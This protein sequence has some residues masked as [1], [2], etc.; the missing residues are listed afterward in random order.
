MDKKQISYE[1]LKVLLKSNQKPILIDVRSKE[2]VAK[3]QI[4]GSIHVPVDTVK[5]AFE[6]DP[7]E[8]KA[9]YGITK[10]LKDAPNLVFHCHMG[11]RGG[12]ATDM[13]HELG[14]TNARNYAG[15]YKEWS[16]K[17]GK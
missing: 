3:G 8:F 13:A 7:E 14:Y 17:E 5:T 4:P 12:L 2:E 1:A 9:K 10:P 6:L 16:E 11:K 15:G